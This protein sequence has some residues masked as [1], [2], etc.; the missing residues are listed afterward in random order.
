VG[1][2]FDSN[3]ADDAEG[4]IGSCMGGPGVSVIVVTPNG[5]WVGVAPNGAYE[6]EGIAQDC[7]TTRADGNGRYH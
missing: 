2:Y 3:V 4:F 6:A 5:S 7:F 1:V